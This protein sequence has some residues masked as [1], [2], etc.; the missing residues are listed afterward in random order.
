MARRIELKGTAKTY[1]G[2]AG[3]LVAA[4]LAFGQTFFTFN[5]GVF[6]H[7]YQSSFL[8]GGHFEKHGFRWDQ[9][10]RTLRYMIST[11]G[12]TLSVELDAEIRRGT[13]V[14]FAWRWPAF[15]YDE[16][17]VHR[18]RFPKGEASRHLQVELSE[19]GIYTLSMSA[20][21]LR[22]DIAVDWRIEE[23]E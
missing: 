21:N 5:L 13:L 9:H 2:I 16:P 12:E 23:D 10:D 17:M 6:N 11:G 14:V 18:T 20:I 19:P 7:G 15:L 3:L 22:G 8:R 1:V 4:W